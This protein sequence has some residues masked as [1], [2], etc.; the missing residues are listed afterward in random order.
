M[1]QKKTRANAG[2]SPGRSVRSRGGRS[3][4]AGTQAGKPAVPTGD[5][6]LYS[7][8]ESE[9]FQYGETLGRT[10][11]GGETILLQGE[12]GT[13]KTVFTRGIAAALGIDPRDVGSPTF[14]LVD[15]HIGR[16]TL[17]HADLYRLDDEEQVLDLGI[18]EFAA[19]GAVVIVE[20]GEKMPA[21]LREGAI[22]VRIADLGDDSRRI[23][24]RARS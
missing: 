5:Q 3:L 18:D 10:L 8:S 9:T 7:L 11:S 13:G 2:R 16:L 15:R 22:E 4:S 6:D 23:T 14:I 12:L 24:L 17:Y 19:A 21:A 1:T 20:W